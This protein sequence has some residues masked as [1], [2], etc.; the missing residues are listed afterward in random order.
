ME[1]N[2]SC[3]VVTRKNYTIKSLAY[4]AL[5][6]ILLLKEAK[7][8]GEGEASHGKRGKT[9]TSQHRG[10]VHADTYNK[11]KPLLVRTVVTTT[12][13]LWKFRY[14]ARALCFP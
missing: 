6:R 12:S 8:V 13:R 7:P 11:T 5:V 10:E 2:I 1:D 3:T 9:K 14:K 4:I